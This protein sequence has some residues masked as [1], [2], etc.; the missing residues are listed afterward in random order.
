MH[1]ILIEFNKRFNLYEI[2]Y[3][4]DLVII[5]GYMDNE[6]QLLSINFAFPIRYMGRGTYLG[7]N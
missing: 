5:R 7:V 1:F 4:G 2:Y 6:L 3:E